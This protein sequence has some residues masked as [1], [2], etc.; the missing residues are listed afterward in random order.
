MRARKFNKQIQVYDTYNE[1]TPGGGNISKDQFIASCWANVETIKSSKPYSD[2]GL[3][4]SRNI[5]KVTIRLRNDLP[6]NSTTMFFVYRNSKFAI[7]NNPTN[8]NYTDAFITFIATEIK[9]IYV[10]G[11]DTVLLDYERRVRNGVGTLNTRACLV[12]YLEANNG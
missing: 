9:S 12:A 8:T 4:F 3:D 5:V 2:L 1:G 11:A 10:A 7:S 6:W